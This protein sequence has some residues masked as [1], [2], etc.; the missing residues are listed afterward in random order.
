MSGQG[1]PII[2]AAVARTKDPFLVVVPGC[3]A[4]SSGDRGK[5]DRLREIQRQFAF[6]LFITGLDISR[7]LSGGKSFA[8][9]VNVIM[10]ERLRPCTSARAWDVQ[11]LHVLSVEIYQSMKSGHMTLCIL[12]VCLGLPAAVQQIK[13]RSIF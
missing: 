12:S 13:V 6:F 10:G 3:K 7:V 2:A 5:T 4:L 9:L 8:I 11:Q 1:G